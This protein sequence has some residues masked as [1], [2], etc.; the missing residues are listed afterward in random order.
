MC[1]PAGRRGI[2]CQIRYSSK[3]EYSRGDTFAFLSGFFRQEERTNRH[4][5]PRSHVG[6]SRGRGSSNLIA[7]SAK[8][9]RSPASEPGSGF[10]RRCS[11]S[12]TTPDPPAF[13]GA[14]K[15]AVA[16]VTGPPATPPFRP[17]HR[18]LWHALFQTVI[19]G[20]TRDRASSGPAPEAALPRIPCLRRG[21]QVRGDDLWIS[22]FYSAASRSASVRSSIAAASSAV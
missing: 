14:G 11:K 15:S 1:H 20:L 6:K 5:A 17:R 22:W 18:R 8:A 3:A 13:A 2:S 12:S 21:R 16:G 9:H 7:G 4:L 19:P 10:L